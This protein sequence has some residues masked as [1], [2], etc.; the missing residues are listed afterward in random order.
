VLLACH[1]RQINNQQIERVDIDLANPPANMLQINPSG[2]VPTLEFQ[3]GEGFHES[4]VI[5][6]FLDTLEAK[7]PKIYG[8]SARQIAQTKVLWETANNTLLSAVQQ[9]IYS[10]GNTN[11]L[12]TAGKRLSTAWSWLSEKLSAQG[13]RFWGGNE[14]NAI[15]VAIAPFLV[16]L[17]YAAEIHK[18]IELP[19][20][21]TRAGQY[22]ADI[23]ERCRQAGIFPEESVMRETTLRFAKPHPLFIEVQNAGRTLLEDPRPRVKDAGSTLS[24]WTVDRDAHGFC[25]SAKFNFKTHTEAV[26]KMKWLHDAQEICDHHTSFTLRD[27]TS[28]E[29]TLVTHEPRWGVTE[30]DF[31]MAKLVQVYF[32]KGSLPQ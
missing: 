26:E 8:D 22:I 2:S 4:L 19:A 7:G 17:K 1:V 25:L 30:K 21:Q 31:A 11:S 10:N 5:M 18:Q 29:I 14:L 24:S 28:I 9:A 32:S 27:F 16:R 3:T 20:A 6:E 12:Q 23:S 15:D 13:S